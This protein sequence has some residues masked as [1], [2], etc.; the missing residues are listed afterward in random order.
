MP[1]AQKTISQVKAMM[2]W[3]IPHIIFSD[4]DAV[5][6]TAIKHY[7]SDH[8]LFIPKCAEFLANKN[9]VKFIDS[10]DCADV[11]MKVIA[12]INDACTKKSYIDAFNVVLKSKI[13]DVHKM[14]VFEILQT[15]W[16]VD[17]NI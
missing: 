12:I 11:R 10:I 2:M 13:D 9:A 1:V 6:D 8:D 16:V 5:Y 17:Q 14:N 4:L 3:I 7:P 15:L